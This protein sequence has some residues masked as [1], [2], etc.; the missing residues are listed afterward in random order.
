[1]VVARSRPR[2]GVATGSDAAFL[3]LAGRVIHCSCVRLHFARPRSPVG[4]AAGRAPARSPESIGADPRFPIYTESMTAVRTNKSPVCGNCGALLSADRLQ[5]T[6]CGS[7][8][9]SDRH[10][11]I[12]DV[13]QVGGY[14]IAGE[15]GSGGMGQ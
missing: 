11:A 12:M 10:P 7:R 14:A 9:R 6:R 13:K 2:S 4:A 5:C 3:P 15:I 8:E 1:L